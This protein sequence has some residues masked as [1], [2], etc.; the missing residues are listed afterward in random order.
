MFKARNGFARPWTKTFE[1]LR[2][3]KAKLKARYRNDHQLL[4]ILNAVEQDLVTNKM[5]PGRW[6]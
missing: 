6:R 2:I 1:F 3:K 4:E 5:G